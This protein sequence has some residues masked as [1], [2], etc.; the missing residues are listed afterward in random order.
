MSPSRE[1][2]DEELP[3]GQSP[4]ER[5]PNIL[6]FGL[7]QWFYFISSAV[8]FCA[9]MVRLEGAWRLVLASIVA[10]IVAHV[11]GTVLGTRLRDTSAEVVRWKAR[12]KS[13]DADAP[14]AT[15]QPVILNDLQLP[16][17][18]TLA[19]QEGRPRRSN[20]ALAIG[21]LLGSFL[22]AAAINAFAGPEVTWPGLAL[23]ST[24][25][26]VIGAWIALLASNFWAIAREAWRHA[27]HQD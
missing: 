3:A 11:C 10:L 25:C 24:S 4:T 14:V 23:G 26:G 13:K 9:L 15:S 2:I 18:T 6:R 20:W 7:R 27:S 19:V 5:E 21:G 16:E 1:S 8:L 22:G 12:P 17:S